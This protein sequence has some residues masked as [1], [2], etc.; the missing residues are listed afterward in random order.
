MAQGPTSRETLLDRFEI[1]LSNEQSAHYVNEGQL[2]AA[3]HNVLAES[4]FAS[5]AISLA[6]VDDRT[7]H[8]LNRQ[9]LNHDYP[10]DVLSFVLEERTEHLEGEVIIS[11]DTAALEAR[12]ANWSADSEQLLYVIHGMLHLVGYRD[13]SPSEAAQ[14]RAAEQKHLRRFGLA[15]SNALAALSST[16]DDRP[17]EAGSP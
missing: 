12:E 2:I 14:M 17:R 1:S 5:A 8:E 13:K 11:A 10:T 4:K 6:I 15:L 3:T 9:Y 7:M 16:D